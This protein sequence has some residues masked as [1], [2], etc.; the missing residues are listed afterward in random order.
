MSVQ[1]GSNLDIPAKRPRSADVGPKNANVKRDDEVWMVDGNVV[2]QA[3][4]VAFKVYWGILARRSTIFNDLFSI[5]RP[6]EV[7]T[8]DGVPIVRLPDS[9]DDLRCL[10]LV[11][12]CGK[13]S[14]SLP[15]CRYMRDF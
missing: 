2:I 3:G 12:C 7:E 10:L 14:S 13:K 11:L 15:I 8:M 9:P 1:S 6:L 5:P 4:Q